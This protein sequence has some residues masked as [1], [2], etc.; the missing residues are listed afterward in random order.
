MFKDVAP[1]FFKSSKVEKYRL[2]NRLAETIGI[3]RTTREIPKVQN[4]D[5]LNAYW[6]TGP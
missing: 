1:Q 4:F 5:M 2:L 6:S 3:M